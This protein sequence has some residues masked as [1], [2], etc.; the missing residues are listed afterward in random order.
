MKIT[1]IGLRTTKISTA[2]TE[3]S[4]AVVVVVTISTDATGE[5]VDAF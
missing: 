2:A 3:S 1:V 5:A 4:V